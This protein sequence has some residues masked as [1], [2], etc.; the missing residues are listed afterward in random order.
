MRLRLHCGL[1]LSRAMSM[2]SVLSPQPVLLAVAGK[3]DVTCFANFSQALTSAEAGSEA[4][5]SYKQ[6]TVDYSR[7]ALSVD[8]DKQQSIGK[9]LSAVGSQLEKSFGGAQDVEGA[10]IGSEIYVVQTRPQP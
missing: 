10:L 7:Q 6:M 1:G 4:V 2:V 3:T 9:S 5:F 8:T